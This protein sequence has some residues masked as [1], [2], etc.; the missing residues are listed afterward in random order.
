[1]TLIKLGT[2]PITHILHYLNRKDTGRL[3]RA[4]RNTRDAVY[5]ALQGTCFTRAI[6]SDVHSEFTNMIAF[7][8]ALHHNAE[9]DYVKSPEQIPGYMFKGCLE[10]KGHENHISSFIQLTDQR[11]ATGSYDKTIK[12]WDSKTGNCIAS[13]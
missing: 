12:I 4:C 10:L 13:F 6:M 8:P 9:Y 3:C 5:S 7:Q 1:M 2:D 11:L